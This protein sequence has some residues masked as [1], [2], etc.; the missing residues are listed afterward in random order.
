MSVFHILCGSLERENSNSHI[1]VK[2][3][4][5]P[6]YHIVM[7]SHMLCMLTIS[8]EQFPSILSLKNPVAL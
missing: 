4:S 7:Q 1:Y 8:S 6:G 3:E 5:N 2:S